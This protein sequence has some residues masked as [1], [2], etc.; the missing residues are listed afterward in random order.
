MGAAGTADYEDETSDTAHARVAPRPGGRCWPIVVAG[1][2]LAVWVLCVL[3]VLCVPPMGASD[4]MCLTGL[5]NSEQA[6]ARSCPIACVAAPCATL[7]SSIARL[8]APAALA[9]PSTSTPGRPVIYLDRGHV[10]TVVRCR[11]RHIDTCPARRR[12]RGPIVS[13][14]QG[15]RQERA[16]FT[17]FRSR[18]GVRRQSQPG[19]LDV[20]PPL[21]RLSLSLPTTTLTLGPPALH[22][23]VPCTL[24]HAAT[25]SPLPPHPHPTLRANTPISQSPLAY[26][27]SPMTS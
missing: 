20:L 11:H 4:L 9:A 26:S 7:R 17:N 27:L 21:P 15:R 16:D 2:G 8:P 14:R 3:Q 5:S 18:A 19:H 6:L 23:P 25:F 24:G 10:P 22:H 12:R 1:E 13:A